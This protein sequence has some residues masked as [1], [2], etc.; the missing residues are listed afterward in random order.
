MKIALPLILLALSLPCSAAEATFTEQY[1]A[2]RDRDDG[3]L[4]IDR[5][6]CMADETKRQGAMLDAAYKEALRVIPV[7]KQPRLR[8]SQREWL[9]FSNANCD[10]FFNSERDALESEARAFCLMR[11]TSERKGELAEIAANQ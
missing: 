1:D 8:E 10:L 11:M 2:C 9:K 5:L 6:N 4:S 3:T 7:A